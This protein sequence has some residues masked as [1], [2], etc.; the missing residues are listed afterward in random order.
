[1]GIAKLDRWTE[2]RRAAADD[3]SHDSAA[4]PVVLSQGLTDMAAAMEQRP[5]YFDP[6][7][8]ET[9]RFLAEATK[10]PRGATKMV[11]YGA[12]RSAENLVSFLG[13]KALGIATNTTG[14]I[15]QHIS[16]AVAT[17]LIVG[18]SG[19]ALTISG[20]LPAGWAWLK[21]LLAALSKGGGG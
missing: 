16:K 12:V 10:D 20:A 17:T 13:R 19:V 7:L 4:N 11:V 21:P 2:F 15:E 9:F 14:A 1:M 5:I 18:L 6:E 3:P 8:P